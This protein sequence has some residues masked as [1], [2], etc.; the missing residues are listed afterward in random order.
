MAELTKYLLPD[1]QAKQLILNQLKLIKLHM[2]TAE[3]TKYLLLAYQ[4]NWLTISHRKA[5]TLLMKQ[6]DQM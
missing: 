1:Y 6:V 5:T 2:K 4:A 3:L